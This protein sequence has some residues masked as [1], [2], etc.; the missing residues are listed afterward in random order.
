VVLVI[1]GFIYYAPLRGH[2]V[3]EAL[4]RYG[5]LSLGVAALSFAFGLPRS[6]CSGVSVG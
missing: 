5:V 3:F 1:L 6:I 2:A 4:W